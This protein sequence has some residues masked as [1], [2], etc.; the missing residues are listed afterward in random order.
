MEQDEGALAREDRP[1]AKTIPVTRTEHLALILSPTLT[2]RNC[3]VASLPRLCNCAICKNALR[4]FSGNFKRNLQNTQAAPLAAVCTPTLKLGHRITS[5]NNLT[6][7]PFY[8][9]SVS[10][11]NKILLRCSLRVSEFCYAISRKR[12]TINKD[13]G[14]CV[15]CVYLSRRGVHLYLGRAPLRC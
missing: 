15:F 5:Q 14:V 7:S 4:T 11:P 8:S 6:Q 12:T 10:V 1:R 3:F 2:W 9:L 13:V